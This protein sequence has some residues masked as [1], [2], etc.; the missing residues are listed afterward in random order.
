MEKLDKTAEEITRTTQ[1]SA[2]TAMH[3]AVKAQKVTYM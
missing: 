2:Y 1:Q 3:Y